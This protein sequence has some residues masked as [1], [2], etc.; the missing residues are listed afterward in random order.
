MG[1]LTE[2]TLKCHR[3]PFPKEIFT[4]TPCNNCKHKNKAYADIMAMVPDGKDD[5]PHG[6][7]VDGQLNNAFNYGRDSTVK[8][9]KQRLEGK[10]TK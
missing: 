10:E 1:V 4:S 3:C 7:Y 2:I 5:K 6:D 9:T 8:L